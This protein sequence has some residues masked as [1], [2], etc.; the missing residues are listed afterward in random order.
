MASKIQTAQGGT[1]PQTQNVLA[2]TS[3]KQSKQVLV[4]NYSNSSTGHATHSS[5]ANFVNSSQTVFASLAKT[6]NLLYC[7]VSPTQFG[8][9]HRHQASS[10]N[11]ESLATKCSKSPG[12]FATVPTAPYCTQPGSLP[13]PPWAPGSACVGQDLHPLLSSALH[14]LALTSGF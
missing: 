13:S 12:L 11:L 8:A 1:H 9:L 5:R 6:Q 3:H 2:P 4:T 10:W 14:S 7:W